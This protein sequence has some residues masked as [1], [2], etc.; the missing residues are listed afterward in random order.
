MEIRIFQESQISIAQGDKDGP[1]DI[2]YQPGK[3]RCAS[4]APANGPGRA[5]VDRRN[6]HT[7]LQAA[8]ESVW[9]LKLVY[10]FFRKIYKNQTDS[11]TTTLFWMLYTQGNRARSC[12]YKNG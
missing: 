8:K 2:I 7:Y 3:L 5:G 11:G 6:F 10:F 4:A 1:P 9:R 12:L